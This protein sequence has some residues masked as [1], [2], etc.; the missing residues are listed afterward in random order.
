[1][2]DQ[3]ISAIVP[4]HNGEA[5]LASA[6][7]SILAQTRACGEVLVVDDGSADGSAALAESFGQ[8]VKVVR[9]RQAGPAA[10][11][12]RGMSEARGDLVAFLDA[13]DLWH[14]RKLEVQMRGF[15]SEPELELSFTLLRNFSGESPDAGGKGQQGPHKGRATAHSPCTLLAR[16]GAIDRIGP[17]DASRKHTHFVDWCMRARRLGIRESV[18]PEVLV[19]RRLHGANRSRRNAARSQGEFLE[20]L[21]SSLDRRRR[22]GLVDDPKT[23]GR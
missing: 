21:K 13:D 3:L 9:Q 11:R 14:P 1:M 16:R 15:D 10:A 19:F 12:N 4:V 18:V 8:R 17:F 23:G 6:L 22:E 7:D 2:P 20:L 5:Y